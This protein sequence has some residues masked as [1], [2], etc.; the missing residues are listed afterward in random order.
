[1]SEVYTL[2]E[3]RPASNVPFLFWGRREVGKTGTAESKNAELDKKRNNR[4]K[5]KTD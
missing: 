4:K 1:V 5:D 3:K 2:N